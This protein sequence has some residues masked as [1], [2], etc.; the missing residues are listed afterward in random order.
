MAVNNR[1]PIVKNG[2]LLYVDAANRNSY[3][4]GSTTWRDVSLNNNN[5]TLIN[6][7]VF[8]NTNG[9]T[10]VFDGVNDYVEVPVINLP[11][12]GSVCVWIYKTGNGLPDGSG[13]VD[14]F[15]NISGDGR[16]GWS[17][18]MN[19]NTSKVDFYIAQNGTYGVEDFSTALI[20]QNTWYNVTCTY[21]G[22]SKAIYINGSLDSIFASTVNGTNT[23]DKWGI[24]SRITNLRC[25]KGYIPIVQAYNRALSASEVAQNYNAQKSRFGL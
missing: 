21:N 16:Y 18:G 1:I 20:N 19:V 7:P 15:S 2:L 11:L 23:V 17:F 5:G 12:S 14:F 4:S 3:N 22:T 10:L 6:G 8:N 24:A 9:G 25:F 13:A